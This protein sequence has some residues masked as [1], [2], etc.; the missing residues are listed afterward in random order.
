MVFVRR[1]ESNEVSPVYLGSA[2]ETDFLRT[3]RAGPSG[4]TSCKSLAE[5]VSK[6]VI[7]GHAVSFSVRELF[8]TQRR[9]PSIPGSWILALAV[10]KPSRKIVNVRRF[11]FPELTPTC[12]WGWLASRYTCLWCPR[13]SD[14]LSGTALRQFC[15][16]ADSPSDTFSSLRR[17]I[18]S[19]CSDSVSV[20]I[21]RERYFTGVATSP[22]P[23]SKQAFLNRI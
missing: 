2:Q 4:L 9:N 3:L 19:G 5:V 7:H 6:T 12:C 1:L 10:L 20:T 15:A 13:N 8:T 11:P 22:I 18:L 21:T 14:L 23:L 16:S 17:S